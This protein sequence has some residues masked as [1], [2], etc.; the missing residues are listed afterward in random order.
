VSKASALRKTIY[1]AIGETTRKETFA[2]ARKMGARRKKKAPKP[3]GGRAPSITLSPS[4]SKKGYHVDQRGRH[5]RVIEM[6]SGNL[7]AI[8]EDG[9]K[10]KLG[11]N[12]RWVLL[13]DK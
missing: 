7:M 2:S 3:G 12:G 10:F 13:K 11:K 6:P 5:Y 9:A 1:K 8:R 4:K